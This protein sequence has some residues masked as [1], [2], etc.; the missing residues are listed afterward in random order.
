MKSVILQF[1]VL[2]IIKE[3]SALAWN[4]NGAKLANVVRFKRMH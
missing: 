4:P 1:R 3:A 2:E